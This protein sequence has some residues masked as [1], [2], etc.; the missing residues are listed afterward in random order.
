[1]TIAERVAAVQRRI[2]EACRRAHRAPGD[3]TLVAVGKTFPAHL[4]REVLAA[5]VADLGENR[6]QE[7]R[8]KATVIRGARWHFVG[9]LQT[10][11]VRHVVGVAALIHSVDRIGI[12]QAIAR[13]AQSAGEV[14]DVLIEVNIGGEASKNGVEPAGVGRL[15]DQLADLDG[16]RV[17]G[18]MTIPPLAP[19]PE[20]SRRF[21][22]DLRSLRDAVV[23]R[24]PAATELSM[25][26]S[27]DLEV[28]I[29]EG[30]T[31]VRVGEAI[32]GSRKR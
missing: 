17:R 21:Y 20:G 23:D 9:P 13:R 3:V 8:E 6:A 19:E 11:K 16:L 31:F 5:G 30:A 24:C 27:R 15:V 4:V 1:M 10:N 28:A 2:E 12:A 7:L 14:Q 32:F 18:L 26:M 29:E 22:A 25:G